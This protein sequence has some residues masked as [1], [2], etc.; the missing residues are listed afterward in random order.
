MAIILWPCGAGMAV[1]A[2]GYGY[3]IFD[4]LDTGNK[5]VAKLLLG[6]MFSIVASVLTALAKLG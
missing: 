3:F 6:I 2:N 4:E 1:Q 5:N